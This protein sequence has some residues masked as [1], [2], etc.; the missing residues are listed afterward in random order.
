[1]AD[2]PVSADRSR[3]MAAIKGKN[4][5]PELLVRSWLHKRGFRFRL[6]RK[7]LPGKPDIV[8]P[9]YRTVILVNGCFWHSHGC[10]NSVLPK[11]RR[12]FWLEKLK[13]TVD[14]DNRNQR[15]LKQS[16]WQVLICWE[17]ELRKDPDR[18]MSRV[19]R[20]LIRRGTV[21]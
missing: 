9:K 11:A 6:H 1:M 14:R 16:N 19:F 15:L 18:P 5:R 8:L 10:A 20:A 12:Q 17:C 2:P 4:T 13:D 3:N 7:D 21:R